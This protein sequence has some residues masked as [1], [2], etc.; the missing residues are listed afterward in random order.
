MTY[1]E[2]AIECFIE[3]LSKT[4][5]S[6]L[7][8]KRVTC[9]SCL[10]ALHASPRKDNVTPTQTRIPERLSGLG[11]QI[12]IPYHNHVFTAFT[13]MLASKTTHKAVF[14][15]FLFSVSS[16][17]P[18]CFREE[19]EGLYNKLIRFKTHLQTGLSANA[20]PLLE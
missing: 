18:F 10:R 5:K 16:I 11:G 9:F 1:T 12:L 2:Q 13:R 4:E 14:P 20:E 15:Q 3:C 19:G 7:L 6:Q 17:V 8:V